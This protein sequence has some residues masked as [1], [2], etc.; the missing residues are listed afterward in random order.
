MEDNKDNKDK[1]VDTKT[2]T[3]N[4]AKTDSRLGTLLPPLDK[5]YNKSD[6]IDCIYMCCGVLTQICI[7]LDCTQK[8][9]KYW[10]R[11]YPE[12]YDDLAA[13]KEFIVAKAEQ[14]IIGAMGSDDPDR[15]LDAAKH[16]MKV[17]G[18]QQPS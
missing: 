2:L 4:S 8:Q 14:V 18:R 16:V 10:L 17:Y 6:I 1:P 12:A 13:A 7:T 15:A 9:F 5:R 3:K 11:K